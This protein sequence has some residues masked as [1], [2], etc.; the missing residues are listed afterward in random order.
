M[1]VWSRWVFAI[2]FIFT[3]VYLKHASVSQQLI[4]PI[5]R[6]FVLR[7][8]KMGAISCQQRYFDSNFLC[9]V[10]RLGRA[11]WQIRMASGWRGYVPVL[12][13]S[14]A[15]RDSAQNRLQ[16]SAGI[17]MNKYYS[18]VSL[19]YVDIFTFIYMN[20]ARSI[21]KQRLMVESSVATI[22]YTKN[23]F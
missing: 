23:C 22:D 12:E 19:Y 2:I 6:T 15:F 5:L 18:H 11:P 16:A 1:V 3:G 10:C 13:K 7:S 4:V 9:L 20:T 14:G 17:R 8:L 21:C